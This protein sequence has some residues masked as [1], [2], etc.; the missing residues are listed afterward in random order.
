MINY[1]ISHGA[2]II[3]SACGAGKTSDIFSFICQHYDEGI[4]YCVDSI[5]E[6]HKMY[7]RLKA[8]LVPIHISADDIM[9]ITSERSAEAEYI[10]Y[11]Y[12]TNP[13]ILLTKKILL[14]THVPYGL[15]LILRVNQ[16]VWE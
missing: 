13:I 9:M 8:T 3:D 11:M 12:Q 4:L 6:L 16:W 7:D 1:F 5:A 15:D 14:I 10:R 2:H